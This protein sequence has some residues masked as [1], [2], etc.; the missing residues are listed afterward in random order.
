MRD[1]A[2]AGKK[3]LAAL[4]AILCAAFLLALFLGAC[5]LATLPGAWR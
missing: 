3:A 5:Y 2:T 1:L 4:A